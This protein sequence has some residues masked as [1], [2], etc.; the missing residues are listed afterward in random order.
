MQV[1][2]ELYFYA[3]SVSGLVSPAG[4]WT[5]WRIVVVPH[6][7]QKLKMN[8]LNSVALSGQIHVSK[9]IDFTFPNPE[10]WSMVAQIT[11]FLDNYVIS[12]V[13]QQ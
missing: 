8:T 2:V 5:D 9:Y 4:N 1:N 3:S 6:G 7:G 11:F 10:R 12:T 13:A